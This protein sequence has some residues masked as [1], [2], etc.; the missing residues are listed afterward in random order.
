MPRQPADKIIIRLPDGL[1]GRIHAAARENRRS[2]NAELVFHLERI[3]P[4]QGGDGTQA[5]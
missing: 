1:R 5:S 3:Y 4:A 2:A